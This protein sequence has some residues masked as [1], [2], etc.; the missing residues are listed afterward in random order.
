MYPFYELSSTIS[1]LQSHYEE[2]VYFFLTKSPGGPGTHLIDLILDLIVH[3][4]SIILMFFYMNTNLD[5]IFKIDLFCNC[6]Q[7]IEKTILF[8]HSSNYSNQRKILFLKLVNIKRSLLNQ[9][10]SII[11]ETFLFGSINLIDKENALITETTI[12][13]IITMKS[14]IALL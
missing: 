7:H 9:N 6:S 1:R 14:F 5:K 13:Y 12:K 2:T 3:L 8:V 11:V 4:M 10:D